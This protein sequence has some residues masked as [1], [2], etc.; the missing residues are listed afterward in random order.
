MPGLLDLVRVGV[1]LGEEPVL[2]RAAEPP[3][4]LR[5]PD[6]AAE[7]DVLVQL[8]YRR[9]RGRPRRRL[10]G[11][12]ELRHLARATVGAGDE[13]RHGRTDLCRQIALDGIA[14]Y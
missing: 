7:V 5:P 4:A 9:R 8:P 11:A 3:L 12:A 10:A 2:T 1:P 6:V 13:H 14:C